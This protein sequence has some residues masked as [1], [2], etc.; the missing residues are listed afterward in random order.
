[1]SQSPADELAALEAELA[2]QNEQLEQ[3]FDAMRALGDVEL[4]ISPSMLDA[5]DDAV[6][7]PTPIDNTIPYGIRA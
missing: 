2:R 1:M 6:R 3:T 7:C 5:I 4:G